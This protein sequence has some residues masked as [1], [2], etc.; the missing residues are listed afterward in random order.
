[1]I[2]PLPKQLSLNA[3]TTIKLFFLKLLVQH[4][5]VVYTEMFALIRYHC[6]II[7]N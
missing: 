6:E 3:N 5:Q 2:L 7:C 4:Q 1:M